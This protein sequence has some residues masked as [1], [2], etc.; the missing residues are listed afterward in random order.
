MRFK[1]FLFHPPPHLKWYLEKSY[2]LQTRSHLPA[3][4]RDHSYFHDAINNRDFNQVS[5]AGIIEDSRFD[6]QNHDEVFDRIVENDYY[7]SLPL[8]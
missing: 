4:E 7:K 6:H 5:G 8:D 1:N 3:L 2:P